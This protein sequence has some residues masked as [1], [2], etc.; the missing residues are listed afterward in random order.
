VTLFGGASLL[1]VLNTGGGGFERLGRH[2]VAALLSALHPDVDYPLSA[3]QII[4]LVQS[5]NAGN[6][7]SIADQLEAFNESLCPLD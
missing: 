6:V 5:A 3:A 1:D 2:A 7:E 4:A